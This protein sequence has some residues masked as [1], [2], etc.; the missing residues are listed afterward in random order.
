MIGR[1]PAAFIV[2]GENRVMVHDQL[3]IDEHKVDAAA[4]LRQRLEIVPGAFRADRDR[5]R[6]PMG[7][8]E[9]ESRM[10]HF[11]DRRCAG[12]GV[13]IAGDD[14]RFAWRLVGGNP[15][16]DLPGADLA[17]SSGMRLSE[18]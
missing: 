2:P 11:L 17:G 10:G 15:A 6:R 13:E 7:V 1:R 3:R 5:P 8:S 16:E 18:E 4:F 9:A 14:D 12:L